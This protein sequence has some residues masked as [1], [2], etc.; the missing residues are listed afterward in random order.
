MVSAVLL[1]LVL[2]AQFRHADNE[3]RG[4]AGWRLTLELLDLVLAAYLT[5][6]VIGVLMASTA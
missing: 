5:S 1:V 4:R 2:P 3:T 6:T